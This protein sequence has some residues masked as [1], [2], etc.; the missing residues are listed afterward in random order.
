MNT[1]DIKEL[2]KVIAEIK[3]SGL[4]EDFLHNILTPKELDD[5]A[6]RLQI[7]KLLFAG[8]PQ[9]EIA[10]KLGVS[11]GTITHGSREIQYGRRGVHKILDKGWRK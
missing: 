11:I 6:R 9:R 8:M 2:S 3:D 7:F 1:K 4:A 10:K 5:V